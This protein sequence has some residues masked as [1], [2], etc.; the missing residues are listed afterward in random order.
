MQRRNFYQRHQKE[1]EPFEGILLRNV[2][3]GR[4]FVLA[5]VVVASY[6]YENSLILGL[7]FFFITFFTVLFSSFI[8]K[9]IPYSIRIIL[10]V[11]IGCVFFV[12]TA[13]YM[14]YLFPQTVFRL[15]AFLPLLISNSLIVIQSEARFNKKSKV[16]M[17]VDLFSHCFG[18]LWV[19]LLVGIIREFL[20]SGN[21]LGNYVGFDYK[22]PSILLPFSG[23]MIVGFLSAFVQSIRLKLLSPTTKDKGAD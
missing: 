21:F 16:F 1:F 15:G 23:F 20:G 11:L 12:P 22:I 14:D 13:L 9:S 19:I 2:A 10:Y 8:T 6:T 4:G 3:I 17:M 5:P 7:S 18:F